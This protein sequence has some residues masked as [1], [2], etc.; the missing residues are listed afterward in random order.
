MTPYD[1]S[2]SLTRRVPIHD[3]PSIVE[4]HGHV[5]STKLLIS[6]SEDGRLKSSCE[7]IETRGFHVQTGPKERLFLS[8]PSQAVSEIHLL[9]VPRQDVPIHLP[10]IRAD[11]RSTHLHQNTQTS[12][13]DSKKDRHP[14][15]SLSGRYAHYEQH[16]R[17]CQK[18]HHDFEVNSREFRISDEHGDIYI[19][20]STDH[21][22]P[23]NHRGLHDHE[24]SPPR[25]E[26][27]CYSERVSPLSKHS[28]PLF[29]STFSH[30][31]E[32]N[33]LQSCSFSSPP[34]LSGIHNLKNSNTFPQVVNN[35]DIPLDPHAL[36]DLRLWEDN[37]YLA[38]G[39]PIRDSV[40]HLMIQSDASN[41]GWGAV[42]N[43]VDTR[44]TWAREESNLHINCKELL[45]ASFAVKAFTKELQ[46]V[47]VLIQIDHY[48]Q[49]LSISTKW[50]GGAK[51][52][53]LDHY[54][55]HLWGWC[56]QRRITLRAEHIPGRLNTAVDRESRAKPDSSDWHLNQQS[57]QIL[58]RD[59]GRCTIDLFAS[60]TNH[61]LPRFYSY[62]PDPE[63]Q[64]VDALIQPWAGEIGYTFNLVAKC[65]RKVIHEAATITLVCPVKPTQPWYAQLLQLVVANPILLPTTVGLL[66]GPQG[67]KHPLVSNK[68]LGRYQARPSCKRLIRTGLKQC[69]RCPES[70]DSESVLVMLVKVGGL[71]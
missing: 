49:P 58:M 10:P 46:N 18:R 16:L 65:L 50:G 55:R 14:D 7:P 38:K 42:S 20:S 52:C 27:C 9:S 67:Q 11:I 41:S 12:N 53:P 5:N 29:K 19:C 23:G 60:R 21:R 3:S 28:S 54:A 33:F 32:V 57:F 35:L 17:G 62:K 4:Y 31:R 1:T 61:Q 25:R 2:R 68:T 43:G 70:F 15:N 37:L 64:V 8:P 45:A 69:P 30:N 6:R 59:L 71:V 24:V 51:R 40:A 66:I 63:A 13:R 22:I 48:K 47:H 56:L 39:R 34:S 26:S 44:R 36:E